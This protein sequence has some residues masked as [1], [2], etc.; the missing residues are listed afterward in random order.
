MGFVRKHQQKISTA[1]LVV[2][3][4][5]AGF[6]IGNQSTISQAQDV[7]ATIG[8]ADEAFEPLF[9]AYQTIQARYVDSSQI[10]VPTLVDGAI[11]GMV[12]SLGD[13]FS[14]YM[15]PQDYAMFSSDLSGNVE[16]IGVVIR[17]EEETGDVVVVSLIKG[18]AAEAAG[19]LPGDIFV[20]V[21]GTNVR[22]LNQSELAMLVR[23]PA[24][25]D[26]T[27]VFDRRGELITLEITRVSFEVPNVEFEMLDNDIAY[28][29]MA[30][31]S[32]TSRSKLDEAVNELDVNSTN[33]LIF[34][35]RGNPG[36]LLSAA[37]D[38]ASLFIEDG[39]ILYESFA[40]GSERV[41]EANGSYGDIEVPIVVL[42]DEGS[43]SASELVS[44]AMQDSG[45]ATLIG[46]TS[47][48]KGTVQTLQP[49]S[50]DGALRITIA[51]YLLP[52]RRWIHDLG[53][54][55]DIEIPYD[56]VEDGD[57]VDP[58]LDAAIDYLIDQQ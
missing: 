20:E 32:D 6:A 39:V 8:D 41:F 15:T 40:D 54:T 56:I 43:A 48:G 42:I 47:F 27:I 10:D 21:D 46:E 44:G 25:S 9:E 13:E 3:V 57:N 58:Q 22:G 19:V 11:K 31:F 30:E 1:L 34:D 55:P 49:L 16:G 37:V 12:E 36:G 53:V 17:T 23:G 24:G 26:V 51:R 5:L 2:I 38:V 52:S 4:F 14:S 28:I 29:S 35:L 33:G 50:N 45:V 18:A 7:P